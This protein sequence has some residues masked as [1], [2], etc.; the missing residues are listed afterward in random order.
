MPD[1]DNHHSALDA[2][3]RKLVSNA[4]KEFVQSQ[5]E[6]NRLVRPT[7][8]DS[9]Q[10]CVSAGI[11]AKNQRAP[12]FGSSEDLE[13]LRIAN[14]A[15]MDATQNTWQLLSQHLVASDSILV[16]TD[17]QGVMLDIKGNEE[18]VAAAANEHVAPGFDWSEKAAGTNAV[19]TALESEL[20]TVVRSVEHYCEAA[21]LWDCAAA[22]IRDLGDGEI[23]GVLDITS[24]GELNNSHALSF[25]ITA[26]KQIEHTLHSLELARSVELLS[27]YRKIESRF[28]DKPVLL[29]DRK[30]RVIVNNNASEN[31]EYPDKFV[32]EN[33]SPK[34]NQHQLNITQ[35]IEYQWSEEESA[36]APS[37]W[38][39][40]LVVVEA[41][42]ANQLSISSRNTHPA[43]D[44][45]ITAN[46]QFIETIDA[47]E[48]MAKAHSP[49]LL[50]GE[51]GSGKELF[52]SAIHE[53]SERA[54]G[55]FVAVNC[56]TLT[57]E[58]A[59]SELFGYEGGAFTGASAKGRRG[60]FEE[61]NH[62]TLFLDEIGEL[63]TDVQ[64]HLLRVLQDNV[65]TRV[66]GNDTMKVDVRVIAATN[67][68]LQLETESGKFRLDLL[69]RL[70]VLSLDLIPLRERKD[71]IP[72][73][74]EKFLERMHATYGLGQKDI[75]PDLM[76]KLVSHQW[77]GNVRELHGV[78]ESIYI[79][80]RAPILTAAHLPKEF[81]IESGRLAERQFDV[82]NPGE[83][84][85]DN[86]EQQ[87][88]ESALTDRNA[89]L[90]Q[91]AN[92]L[93][94]S[95]STLYRK[96]KRYGLSR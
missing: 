82:I 25:A 70:K 9:W 5:R 13:A 28:R 69:Y 89:S 83:T 58:L 35:T 51:T 45:I 79:L 76:H 23:I 4:W 30:G 90:E 29:L 37:E 46:Y 2:L 42:P 77:P 67:K 96:M 72:L 84:K 15:L 41:L 55:P 80:N 56:G 48:R 34:T 57:Q 24:V 60:K 63:P 20:P 75:A 61:A 32:V 73:L 19:G 3:D 53:C 6:P 78:I 49:V 21:K 38:S 93:G 85:L 33:N 64:S 27:W 88:I 91:I 92:Q 44:K 74:V 14:K 40:G 12:L 66:G 52:A 43:F 16:L 11:D 65:V 39:G 31:L 47:A 87:L 17:S 68:N 26:A 54:N 1:R 18:I 62:G 8:A 94:I 81:Q 59:A 95:R 86:V 50:N 10:R 71:D 7:I 22:P 36:T